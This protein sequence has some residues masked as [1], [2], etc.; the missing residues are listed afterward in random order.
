MRASFDVCFGST[1]S[2]GGF[3][4][5]SGSDLAVDVVGSGVDSFG[6]AFAGFERVRAI[7]MCMLVQL[8]RGS[9]LY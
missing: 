1:N 4:V 2:L 6:V 3:G 5:L 8:N 7:V 9:I